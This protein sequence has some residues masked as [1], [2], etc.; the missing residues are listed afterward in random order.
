MQAPAAPAPGAAV[1][2][3]VQAAPE[4]P[5]GWPR[6][7]DTAAGSRIIIYQ[8]QVVSWERQRDLVAMAAISH[9]A[10]GATKPALGT[11]RL[12]SPTSVSMDDRVVKLERIKITDMHFPT[13]AKAHAQEALSEIQKTV[14]DHAV[15]MDL[16]RAIAAVDKST[17]SGKS[18]QVSTDPP[19]I[20]YSEKPAILVMFDGEAIWTDLDKTTLEYVLNTNWDVF[21]EKGQNV[22]YLRDGSYWLQTEDLKKG[23]WEPV[24]KL[25][26]SFEQIPTNDNWAKVKDN[27]PGKKISKGKM[28]KVFLSERPA[29][30]L[31]LTG[32]PKYEPIEKKSKLLWVSNTESDL[33]R[34]KDADFY[35][36]VAGRW[37]SAPKPEGPWK[38][39]S[40][41]LPAEFSAIPVDHERARVRSSVPGT[42]EAIEAVLMAGIPQT[43]TVDAKSLKPPDVAYSGEPQFKRIEGS[44]GV[45]YAVNTSSDVLQVGG[46]YYLCA[47]GVWFTSKNATGPWVV[48]TDVPKAIYAMPSSSPVYHV[49]YVTVVDDDENN[50]TYASTAGYMGV[51][52]AFGCAMWG[53]GYYYPPY[54]GHYGGYPIYHPYPHTY[55]AG[56]T[57]NP[58]TGRYGS[59]QAAYGPYGGVARTSSYNPRTG[60]YSRGQMAWGPSGAQGSGVAYNPRTGAAGATRQGSNPYGNWG[61][62]AVKKGDDWARTAR[63]TDSQGNTRWAAQGSGGGSA[64]GVRG[65]GGS[66]FVGQSGSGDVYAGRDGNVYRKTDGGWQS[67]DNGN[68]NDVGGSG[69][70]PSQQ[71]GA[72]TRPSQQPSTGAGAGAGTRPSQQ[73]SAGTRP[74]PSQGTMGQLD[75]DAAGRSRGT[76]RSNSYGSS[77][78]SSSSMARSGG[79]MRGGGR[80]R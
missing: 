50:P 25:P 45:S 70:R 12:Q 1:A 68:W 11:L 51:T 57:Y 21:R 55:G 35:Y 54:Y 3:V 33:F 41:N 65:P 15:F 20:H 17:I 40:S 46:A 4:E 52:V 30:M 34:M 60:T 42:D 64:T 67:Y 19:T 8:P 7:I 32:K 66:G 61:T 47:S 16:D 56:T 75:R 18:V 26:K 13:L 24:S 73:P 69:N 48:T 43:A 22:V 77:S 80:R 72:G 6:L 71:P 29:E 23:E 36:L 28:P 62:S 9:L 79:G 74:A 27:V 78:R 5:L 10:K 14:P 37:F 63:V 76:Q 49:T 38:F 44:S 59:Y 53:T 39:A 31:L 58:A 2:P